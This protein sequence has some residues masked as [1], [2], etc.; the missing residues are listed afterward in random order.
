MFVVAYPREMQEMVLDAHIR[1][2]EFFGGVPSR[3]IYDNLKTVVD[4]I[5]HGVIRRMGAGVWRCQDD[6]G[7]A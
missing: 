4:T 6:H 1:A 3:L 2:F 7:L 5:Y